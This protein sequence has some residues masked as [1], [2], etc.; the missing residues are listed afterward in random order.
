MLLLINLA[1]KQKFDK[2][3]MTNGWELDTLPNWF[4]FMYMFFGIFMFPF[5]KLIREFRKI[6]YMKYKIRYYEF[7]I[8]TN[9]VYRKD[10]EYYDYLGYKRY[11][12]L[13]ILNKKTNKNVL[14]KKLRFLKLIKTV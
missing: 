7:S 3:T 6:E 9:I 1:L 14:F 8:L 13:F 5:Y 2:L 10:K 4:I 12:K 11:L